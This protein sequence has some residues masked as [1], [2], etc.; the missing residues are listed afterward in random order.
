MFPVFTYGVNPKMI[1]GLD[2]N[3]EVN[4]EFLNDQARIY[5]GEQLSKFFDFA[6]TMGYDVTA[7]NEYLRRYYYN[8]IDE[9]NSC[10]LYDKFEWLNYNSFVIEHKDIVRKKNL[11]DTIYHEPELCYLL[12][13]NV[14]I[15]SSLSSVHYDIGNDISKINIYPLNCDFRTNINEK[16]GEI[17]SSECVR[18]QPIKLK[19]GSGIVQLCFQLPDVLEIQ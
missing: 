6:N 19:C 5:D 10:H 17:V 11:E 2:F 16:A 1:F 8:F 9:T 12:E 3:T 4:V 18:F 13:G 7:H 15:T 14:T